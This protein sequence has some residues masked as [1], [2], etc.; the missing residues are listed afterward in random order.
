MIEKGEWTG[1]IEQTTKDGRHLVVEMHWSLVRDDKGQPKAVLAINTDVT[2][3]KRIEQQF[4]RAQRMESIGTLAGGIAHDLNN[5]LAPI[6]MSIELLKLDETRSDKLDI[7]ATI[8]SSA[9]RGADM[10][11]QVLSFARG[12]EG[13]Q[14]RLQPAH[15]VREVAKIANETFLKGIRVVT[16]IAEDL[17]TLQGDPTQLHQVLLNLSV[18]ARDAMPEGGTLTLCADN[19]ELEAPYAA[20]L[21]PDIRP[22]RHV[23]LSVQ[24]TGTGMPPEVLERIFD[25]FFSTKEPGK[26][27]GLGLSTAQAIVRSHGGLLRVRSEPG[28]GTRF[29]LYLPALEGIE[30]E[31]PAPARQLPRG[32][33]QTVLIVDDEEWVRQIAR[34]TLQT[35]GYRVLLA[36]DGAE[37]TAI[38]AARH[39]EIDV[40]L[41]D[42]MMPVM[43]GAAAIQVLRRIAPGARILASSGLHV[44]AMKARAKR[45][46]VRHFIPKPYTTET[47]LQALHAVLSEPAAAHG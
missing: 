21:G 23:R 5:V 34:Q 38:F 17:W 26:G 31:P 37:A 8:E 42:M 2:G 20:S 19:L 18:N 16:R 15:L 6:L 13:R 45:A 14:I 33:G 10:V 7:L 35:F 4:L 29:D 3:R 41:T 11:R 12:V 32:S 1:E 9:Q 46:G 22:G 39:K 27:T 24:D 40:V 44:E 36:A 43:D 25:P 28:E 47:L 30:A